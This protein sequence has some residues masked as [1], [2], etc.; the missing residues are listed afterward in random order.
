[1]PKIIKCKICGKE[2]DV[3]HWTNTDEMIKHQ[4]CFHCNFWRE[5]KEIDEN[6]D[7]HTW[8]MINGTHYYLNPHTDHYFKGFGG[9]KFRIRFNDG[10]ETVCDN[11]WCQGEPPEGYWRE[12][13]PDNAT[14]VDE[15][16]WVE[17][18]EGTKYLN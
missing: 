4:M 13:F 5:K 17:D 10:F 1:M 11:L 7:Y 16:K 2:E 12:Q 6:S 8:A 9:R 14:F 18:S 3:S 15:L